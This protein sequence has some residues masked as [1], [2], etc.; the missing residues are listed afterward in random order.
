MVP[1]GDQDLESLTKTMYRRPSSLMAGKSRSAPGSQPRVRVTLPEGL[2]L[3]DRKPVGVFPVSTGLDGWAILALVIGCHIRELPSKHLWRSG[4]CKP[5]EAALEQ[6]LNAR[7]ETLKRI[8]KFFFPLRLDN[9]LSLPAESSQLWS[10]AI[11]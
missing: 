2:A 3:E 8:Y 5:A 7:Y 10:E 1:D 11:S 9:D 6:A 4:I